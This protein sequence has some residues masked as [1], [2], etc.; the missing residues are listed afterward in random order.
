MK[1]KFEDV[2]LDTL[3][4]WIKNY[5][6]D[7][8]PDAKAVIGISGGKDSTVCAALLCRALGP[9]NVIAVTMPNN[10]QHDINMAFKVIDYLKIPVANCH[11]FNIKSICN[12]FSS[13]LGE[14]FYNDPVVY[15]NLPARVRMTILYAI[16]G[17]CHGR[18]CNTCNR[19]EEY[20]GYSTKY[21]D[22]AGDFSPLKD[23]TVAEVKYIG[24]L[25][26]LPD[27]FINKAPE[28]GLCGKTDEENLGFSYE[29]LDSYLLNNITPEWPK[30][31]KIQAR[32]DASAHKRNRMPQ[33]PHKCRGISYF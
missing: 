29:E 5:F 31:K 13:C 14:E 10:F 21:G 18:V 8:G 17:H 12:A 24:T 28:D 6:A 22:A 33:A 1:S 3:T 9:E 7:N 2:D 26:G 27:E 15:T 4:N 25:L 16:A 30:F 11:N 32:H 23:Y 19:S 20:I